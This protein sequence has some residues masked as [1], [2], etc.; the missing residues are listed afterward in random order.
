MRRVTLTFPW[1]RGDLARDA[2]V[3]LALAG[4]HEVV[5]VLEPHGSTFQVWKVL[6]EVDE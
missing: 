4:A 3:Q 1:D 5:T 6:A 2:A